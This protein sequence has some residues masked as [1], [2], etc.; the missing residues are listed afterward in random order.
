MMA[1]LSR[2]EGALRVATDE[3][4]QQDAVIRTLRQKVKHFES[5]GDPKAEVDSARRCRRLER[6][7][8]QMEIFLADYGM[9][10]V[11]E[12]DEEDESPAVAVAAAADSGGGGAGS[13]TPAAARAPRGTGPV[14]PSD[15][16]KILSN[17]AELNALAGE[18]V[19]TVAK[20]A[21]GS[22]KIAMP[23]PV[24]L[25][26]YANGMMLFDGPF[27][28]LDETIAQSFLHDV[29]DG[30][31]PTELQERFPDGIPFRAYDLRGEAYNTATGKIFPGVG[32]QVGGVA[33]SPQPKRASNVHSMG[34]LNSGAAPHPQSAAS[35]LNKLPPTVIRKGKIIDIR[36]DIA[37]QL[38][39]G[40]GGGGKV[41]VI[42]T[43][44]VQGLKQNAAAIG[45][46][47][48]AHRPV[49]PADIATLQVKSIDGKETLVLKLRF[50]DTIGTARRWV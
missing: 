3:I 42:D 24:T 35:L 30:Y 20:R 44:V 22:A 27:R 19:G 14:T 8:H 17:V 25:R 2:A 36:G 40:G 9:I 45:D 49:T 21:D 7:V 39:A 13:G 43:E 41:S 15:Y 47:A 28:Q 29:L 6:T 26:L 11:G 46:G 34:D 48:L 23:D 16:D 5:V 50:S 33:M 38:A 12:D 32:H 10:W 1:R 4:A 37:G 18:G 31:F